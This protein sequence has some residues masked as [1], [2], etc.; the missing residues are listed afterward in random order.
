MPY[1]SRSCAPK[2]K[3]SKIAA[4]GKTGDAT[5]TD[6]VQENLQKQSKLVIHN[7]LLHSY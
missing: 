2:K 4:K 7:D 6:S 5:K 1:K 3:R